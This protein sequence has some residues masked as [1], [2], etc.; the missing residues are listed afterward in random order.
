MKET[1]KAGFEAL[2]HLP[3]TVKQFGRKT[4]IMPFFTIM[5]CAIVI[6]VTFCIIAYAIVD[7]NKEEF[8]K[9]YFEEVGR[10]HF[11]ARFDE[12]K[13][14]VEI[15]ALV[16]H[17]KAAS[18][19][20]WAIDVGG[21]KKRLLYRYLAKTG[22]EDGEFYNEDFP[23]FYYNEN[24]TAFGDVIIERTP[25]LDLVPE[26]NYG[27]RMASE[28]ISFVCFAKVPPDSGQF[29]GMIELEFTSKPDELIQSELQDNPAKRVTFNNRLKK[30]S[31]NIIRKGK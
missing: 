29:I 3:D 2:K 18:A 5:I 25:C 26:T 13:F 9:A 15:S 23:L 24:K 20:V 8:G 6:V 19:S 28:G 12:T 31:N 17:S 16:K 27:D 30:A 22:K 11:I 1:L 10:E 7:A 14:N 4:Y 21:N